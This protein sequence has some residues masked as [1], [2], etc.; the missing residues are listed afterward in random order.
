MGHK[1]PKFKKGGVLI[2]VCPNVTIL[3]FTLIR[4][5]FHTLKVGASIFCNQL[6]SSQM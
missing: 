4:D 5:S 1:D 2:L 3:E 6:V